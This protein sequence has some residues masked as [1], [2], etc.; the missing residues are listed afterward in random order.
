MEN[1]TTLEKL[2]NLQQL[3]NENSS[4]RAYIDHDC[5]HQTFEELATIR[6]KIGQKPKAPSIIRCRVELPLPENYDQA[7]KAERD[8]RKKTL[9]SVGAA[10]AILLILYFTTHANFLN[11]MSTIGIFATAIVGWFYKMSNDSYKTKSK[12]LQD[13]QKAY[14]SSLEQFQKALSNYP[15]ELEAIHAEYI[16]YRIRHLEN[17]PDFMDTVFSYGEKIEQAE[18]ALAKNNALIADS[19][20]TA[21][22]YFHLVPKLVSMLK[23]GRADSYKEALNMAIA[24]ERQEEIEAARR[25]EDARRIAVMEQ[26]AEEERR[27][28]RMMEEQQERAAEDARRATEDAQRAADK[29]ERERR[30]AGFR[31]CINCANNSKC[32]IYVQESGAGLTC[33]GYRPR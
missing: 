30:S 9:L 14:R 10:L 29:A 22:E 32:S 28:N 33:G 20:A 21:P 18:E 1:T 25:E 11:T 13:S 3:L 12:E 23:S 8:K 19:D 27:H 2:E 15:Q 4:L 26:Q 24:E 7:A 6:E 5:A 31:K 16:Q 17:Y